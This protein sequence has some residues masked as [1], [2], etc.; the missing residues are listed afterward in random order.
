MAPVRSRPQP[1]HVVVLGASL[2]GS[3]A[4]AAAAAAAAAGQAER[5]FIV[6][7]PVPVFSSKWRTRR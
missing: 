4:A 6:Y 2:A 7:V 3:F 5:T 1:R